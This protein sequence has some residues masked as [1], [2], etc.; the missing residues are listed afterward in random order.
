M[1]QKNRKYNKQK[2]K[3]KN[4]SSYVKKKMNNQMKANS[5]KA[6]EQNK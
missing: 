2:I 5:N 4:D 6:M 1:L 3:H